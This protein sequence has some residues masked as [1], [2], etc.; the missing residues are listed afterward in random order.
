[1]YR[2]IPIVSVVDNSLDI[3]QPLICSNLIDRRFYAH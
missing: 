2:E 1:M 3:V